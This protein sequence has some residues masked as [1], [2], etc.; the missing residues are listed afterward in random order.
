MCE[1][2]SSTIYVKA[3]W[4]ASPLL[5]PW[6]LDLQKL[7]KTISLTHLVNEEFYDRD[8]V[9]DGSPVQW[10]HV[11][12]VGDED[13]GEEVVCLHVMHR[14]DHIQ[15]AL[16]TRKVKGSRLVILEMKLW[17]QYITCVSGTMVIQG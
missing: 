1:S 6:M 11:L 14:P 7:R 3:L 13:G 10:R 5:Y 15:V 12:D 16:G 2:N 8:M 17:N 4:L 9:K